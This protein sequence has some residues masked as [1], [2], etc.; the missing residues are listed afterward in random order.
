MD[1]SKEIQKRRDYKVM[2]IDFNKKI[3]LELV[4]LDG[5][6]FFLMGAFSKRAKQEGWEQEEIDYV[7]WQCKQGD[8]NHLLQILIKHTKTDKD[9]P[10]VIYHNGRTYRAID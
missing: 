7:L 8:Y 6:A 9:N 5:N 4:G 3:T 1:D 10:E 2:S